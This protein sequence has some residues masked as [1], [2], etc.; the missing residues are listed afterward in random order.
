V[1]PVAL[2]LIGILLLF[3]TEY[4]T[5]EAIVEAARNHALLGFVII[6]AGLFKAVEVR[7]GRE[8]KWLAFPWIVMLLISALMLISYR[9][10]EGAYKTNPSDQPDTTRLLPP[11]TLTAHFTFT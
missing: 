11:K 9:E 1:S 6:L 3:H 10:P 7:W 8:L 4:G 5:P 2:V